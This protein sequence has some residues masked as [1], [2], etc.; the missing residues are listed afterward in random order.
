MEPEKSS[1]APGGV[2]DYLQT[3]PHRR[4]VSI[5]GST[6]PKHVSQAV[7]AA[8]KSLIATSLWWLDLSWDGKECLNLGGSQVWWPPGEESITMRDLAFI[9]NSACLEFGHQKGMF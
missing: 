3:H 4:V 5:F 1:L 7:H 2:A 9:K 8:G 6:E